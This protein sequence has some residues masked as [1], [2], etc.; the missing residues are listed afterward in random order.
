MKRL[1][2]TGIIY[3]LVQGVIAQDIKMT[4]SDGISNTSVK[5][6]METGVSQLLSEI[7]QACAQERDLRLDN[8]DMALAGKKSLQYLWQN[9]HFFCE[10]NE[11]LERC[12]TS[13]EGYVIRNIFIQV[14]P[15]I[16]DYTDERERALTIRLSREGQIASVV[17][18]ASD[19]AY[20]RIVQS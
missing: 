17:M 14:N 11:I 4:I 16:E 6:R 7:N 15:M 12:L 19:M 8:V 5:Q 3:C 2:I 10:D 1:L 18:A 20:E 9:L 13:A